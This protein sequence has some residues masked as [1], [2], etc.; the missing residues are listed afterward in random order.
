MKKILIVEDDAHY[1]ELIKEGLA[2]S[3]HIE[4]M[5]AGDGKTALEMV[6]Q[7]RD[8]NLIMLDLQLPVMDGVTFLYHLKNSLKRNIPVIVLT[9][10]DEVQ[11]ENGVRAVLN[12]SDI[13]VEEIVQQVKMNLA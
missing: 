11:K 12:K 9:N 10:Y 5:F 1:R 8:I 6:E 13:S 4:V 3:G 7:H 2:I